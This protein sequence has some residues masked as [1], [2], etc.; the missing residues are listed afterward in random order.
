MDNN[1]PVGNQPEFTQKALDAKFSF[2]FSRK[3]IIVLVNTL[4]PL[5]FAVA[6][7]RGRVL[8]EILDEIERT[9]IQSIT[10]DDYVAQTILTTNHVDAPVVPVIESKEKVATN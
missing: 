5:Q 10:T 3:Q 4:R 1:Q 9:A 8:I 7:L 6:D 2:S